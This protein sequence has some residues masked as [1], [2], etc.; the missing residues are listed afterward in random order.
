MH[1]LVGGDESA[2]AIVLVHGLSVSHRYMA[3]LARK[4]AGDFHVF[5]PDLPGFGKS[6][7]PTRTLGIPQ[8]ARSLA[9][10]MDVVGL[11]HAP[12]LANSL[13][14]Q[15]VVELAVRESGRADSLVLV[16]P[17]IDPNRRRAAAQIG[18][19]LLDAT[20]EPPT[21]PLI[22][23]RDFVACGAIR[24]LRTFRDALADP[25]E[26]KLPRVDVPTLL[27]RGERDAIVPRDWAEQA[28]ALLPRGQLLE[29][30]GAGHAVNYNAPQELAKVVR[31]FLRGVDSGS[32]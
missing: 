4:L 12:L 20:R 2:P 18:R 28:V 22:I 11:A 17:T 19:W 14:C 3:P 9:A 27:V 21:L 10:W 30:P 26:A 13:G 16:G 5:A 32:V 15:V 8:L 29:I 25:V 6:E 1:A 7:S 31:D 23:V 24:T